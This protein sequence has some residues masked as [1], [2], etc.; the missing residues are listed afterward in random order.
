MTPRLHGIHHSTIEAERNSNWSSG[1]TWWD[2]LHGTLRFDVPQ[3]AIEIGIGTHRSPYEVT[4]G[5]V[6]AMP[7]VC[8]D[9]KTKVSASDAS[10]RSAWG[11]GSRR[12]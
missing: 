3:E 11:E 12:D 2:I 5:K 7:F 8:A 4:L 9:R 1:L 10:P 6:L